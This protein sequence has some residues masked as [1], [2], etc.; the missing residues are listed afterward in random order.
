MLTGTAKS[1]ILSIYKP[2][3]LEKGM[4]EKI[5]QVD[6]ADVVRQRS[7]K[8][9]IVSLVVVAILIGGLFGFGHYLLEGAKRSLEHTLAEKQIRLSTDRAKAIDGWLSGHIKNIQE[10][11]SQSLLVEFAALAADTPGGVPILFGDTKGNDF[12]EGVS[13]LELNFPA[14]KS[15]LRGFVNDH[16][17]ELDSII[18]VNALC[19]PYLTTKGEVEPLS[20]ADKAIGAQV[21]SSAFHA[22]SPIEMNSEGAF[23]S[24]F[25]PIMPPGDQ[26]STK[27]SAILVVKLK[28][29]PI[30]N[31]TLSMGF[32]ST[33]TQRLS[34]VQAVEGDTF[35]EVDIET[36]SLL[37]ARDFTLTEKQQLPFGVRPS[38]SHRTDVYSLGKKLLNTQW[39]VVAEADL[40]EV[41][42]PL[43]EESRVVY[44]VCGLIAVVLVLLVVAFWW[45]IMG[46]QQRAVNEYFRSLLGV[47][48][49]Q[50]Q[51]LD[52][53]NSTIS[54]PIT[55]VDAEGK[56]V[57]CN[58]A[59]G[60]SVG[61]E[62]AEIVG[63]D[64]Q[65]VFGYDTAKR[66]SQ[67]D[68]H[69]LMTGEGLSTNETLWLQS[70]RYFFQ[71]S[72]AP[73]YDSQN[74]KVAGIV[75]V[76]R[77]ITQIIEGEQHS[78]RLVQQTIDA[79][80]HA[81]E[82]VDP[83]LGG[84]SHIMGDMAVLIAKQ[85][86]LSGGDTATIEAAASLS[87]IGKMYIPREILLKPGK[88]S[89]EEKS[90]MEKHVQ[91]TWAVLK[92]VEFDLPVLDAIRQMNES[93]DGS[94]Y[95]AGLRGDAISIHARVLAV[96][97]AFAAMARPRSY[98][99]ALPI[100]Q[101]LEVLDKATGTVYDRQVV[102]ALR[103]VIV[104]PQGE[105]IIREAAMKKA[106]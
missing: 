97:N 57:Y 5:T 66:L 11:A 98:R 83:F 6:S 44:T 93:L 51:L 71:I 52:G 103:T 46:R 84:H 73:L 41:T 85:L 94:G 92:D 55:L 63:L 10:M 36:R 38:P 77:D 37:I 89:D 78:R 47:I 12:G 8:K 58:K 80:V 33:K 49:E 90:Q 26:L 86:H 18:L 42:E 62:S 72:K 56:F 28:V 22:L 79:L 35:Q 67:S 104:T 50:K 64:G 15:A 31:R 13:D 7:R 4:S 105:R 76:Y 14:L 9:L 91:Y 102:D 39:W 17:S 99:D 68:Q 3:I 30:L 65:A 48:E 70:K 61:R 75:S 20:R 59:F 45:S 87:Q 88:L 54:D 53:I 82:E 1:R 25:M 101:V 43:Q 81:I 74:K 34:L 2:L 24:L 21:V 95:P 106:V 27:P 16:S 69:V 19:E 29:L 40:Q 60:E 23:T 32:F 96:V 100:D